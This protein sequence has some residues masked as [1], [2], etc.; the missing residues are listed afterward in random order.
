MCGKR[1]LLYEIPAIFAPHH[2][3]IVY[4]IFNFR[5][6]AG[7]ENAP[8]RWVLTLRG[9]HRCAVDH[10][11]R[12]WWPSQ[13]RS[14]TYLVQSKP[15]LISERQWQQFVLVSQSIMV[16]SARGIEIE[17]QTD[18]GK[19]I[20]INCSFVRCAAIKRGQVMFKD[21]LHAQI[22][23]FYF[24]DES[25]HR[26]AK[27]SE[28][29]RHTYGHLFDLTIVNN[30]IED[31]IRL[32]EDSLERLGSQPQW[33]PASWIYW[34]PGHEGTPWTCADF[35]FH[36]KVARL[37]ACVLRRAATWPGLYTPQAACRAIT[38]KRLSLF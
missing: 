8:D 26:L 38:G 24:Q 10:W 14:S 27:E 1:T 23:F 7:A 18:A 34:Q 2:S 37:F 3:L 5:C 6:L 32:L 29:L 11:C 9:V 28:A 12:K 36:V 19:R 15:R 22:V 17:L 20:E 31:T 4:V 21:D 13:Y 30:D 35:R 33:V 16:V 25:L